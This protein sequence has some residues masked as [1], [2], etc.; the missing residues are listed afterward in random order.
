MPRSQS[1]LF[2]VRL[3]ESEKRRIKTLA[4]SQGLTFRQATVRAYEAW[5]SQLQSQARAADPA[6]GVSAGAQLEKPG[7]R[8]RGSQDPEA[9]PSTG[10]AGSF[11]KLRA[12]PEAQ[13]DAQAGPESGRCEACSYPRRSTRGRRGAFGRVAPPGDAVGLVKV[14]RGGKRRHKIRQGLAC[15]LDARAAGLHLQGPGGRAPPGGNCGGLRDRRGTVES[16]PPVRNRGR[17]ADGF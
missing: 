1:I 13:D 3:T 11:D 10:R 5:A 16:Y 17:G 15:P 2:Q 8:N 12:G 7:K 6:L 14:S 4:A 9:N